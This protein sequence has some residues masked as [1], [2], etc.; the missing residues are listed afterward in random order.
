MTDSIVDLPPLPLEDGARLIVVRAAPGVAR[1]GILG[2]WAAGNVGA[3]GRTYRLSCNFKQSGPWSGVKELVEQLLPQVEEQAP[4]LVQ[5]HGTEIFL[6]APMAG[7]R[8]GLVAPSLTDIAVPEEKV[9]NYPMDRAYRLVHGLVDFVAASHRLNGEGPLVLICDPFAD[10]GALAQRFFWELLRREGDG[11]RLSLVLALG[12]DDPLP[13]LFVGF[14]STT[15][16]RLDLPGD[17]EAVPDPQ[18][19][20]DLAIELEG[21]AAGG[22]AEGLENLSTLIHAWQNSDDPGRALVWQAQAFGQYNHLGFYEDALRYGAV[23]ENGIDR[24]LEMT[25]AYTRWNLVGAL[26]NCHLAM[27]EPEA[28][29]A[30]INKEGRHKIKDPGDL[31]KLFYVEA[32]IYARFLAARD[33]AQAEQRLHE[34]L[35]LLETATLP[36][37]E[38]WF[39]HVFLLNGLAYIRHRQGMPSEAIELCQQGFELLER[40]LA[41][42]QHRL[43]R[44]VLLYNIAQ[45]YAHLGEGEKAVEHYTG[46]MRFDPNY[47]E[48]YNERGN[49]Y[50]SMGRLEEAIGDYQE[51][52]RLSAPYQEVWTNMGQALKLQGRYEESFEA[53][54]KALDLDPYQVLP[55]IGRAQ[56]LEQ[57]ER[58]EEA[59]VDYSLALEAD[60]AQPLVLAN[61]A[62][63]LYEEGRLEEAIADLGKAMELAPETP[64]LYWNRAAALKETG[65]LGAAAQDWTTYLELLPDADDREDVL[66]RIGECSARASIAGG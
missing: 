40:H 35:A 1:R 22:Y 51:A 24:V 25:S 15:E 29:L 9:R 49:A 56:A 36:E 31:A 5:R 27:G 13:Q 41:P 4:E 7:R 63:L 20:R 6:S 54:S 10:P 46:A 45:V 33:F 3:D 62:A 37:E 42:D 61:R 60:P 2:E 66:A 53:Y 19:M 26:A 16:I 38:R 57:L 21:V 44:S 50:L 48:Y 65:A 32:L 14:P 18:V 34:G 58:L 28:A 23:I 39:L 59:I 17:A 47:S 12:P 43:H 55:R 52:I 30:V 8:I 11:L 64:D